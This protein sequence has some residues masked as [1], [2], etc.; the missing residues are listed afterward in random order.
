MSN[1]A[2]GLGL[3]ANGLAKICDRLLIPYP[4]R[5]YWAKVYAGKDHAADAA[6]AGARRCPRRGDHHS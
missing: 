1:I 6:A 5:G 3:S 4:T 2:V